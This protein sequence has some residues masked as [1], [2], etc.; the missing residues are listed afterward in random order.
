MKL[1]F[2]IIIIIIICRLL[3]QEQNNKLAECQ[4][5]KR[6]YHQQC[7]KPAITNNE[8][9]DPRMLWYCSKCI[10]K[11]NRFVSVDFY[12]L[13]MILL[14]LKKNYFFFFFIDK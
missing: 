10:K 1:L 2:F 5:C 3:N 8:I 14:L 12:L 11:V 9:Q 4:E 6:L 13:L 7:H